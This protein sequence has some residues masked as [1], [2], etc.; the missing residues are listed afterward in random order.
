MMKRTPNQLNTNISKVI[1]NFAVKGK[2]KLIGSN[3]LRSTLYGSDYDV[4][5]D[6]M[7]N[8][9]QIARHF[10]SEYEKAKKDP[11]VFITDF[12][13]GWDDRLVYDGDYSKQSLKKYL[14]NPL[15]PQ[16]MRNAIKKATGEKQMDLVRDLFIL[17][18]K[19]KD[20]KSGKIKLID[21]TYKTLEECIM[22]KTTLKIDL[23]KKVGDQFCEISENYYIKTKD[24]ATNYPVKPDR[25]LL[26]KTLEDDIRYYA[27]TNSFKALKRLFSLYLIEGDKEPEIE[28]MIDF[29]N[30]QVGYLNKVRA[31]LEILEKVLTQDFRKPKWEDIKNNLQFIKEQ[32][33]SVFE[34]PFNEKIFAEIDNI[35][36]KTALKDIITIKDYFAKKINE[37]SKDFLAHYI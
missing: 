35:T 16:K 17:R 10:Q 18:W 31:E 29:F 5:A 9:E 25:K 22:D 24:G 1:D 11:Y 28:K 6:L 36:E 33:S 32:L 34:I 12:K 4:E 3:S 13:C 2:W 8:P 14:K 20:V 21:G 37:Y 30:S 27:P 23:I 26:E 19:P 15:I 7:Q